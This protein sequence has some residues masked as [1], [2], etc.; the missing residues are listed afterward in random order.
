MAIRNLMEDVVASVAGEV[1]A[2]QKGELPHSELYWDDIIAYVLNRV[3]ARYITSERG[4]LH[5]RIDSLAHVQQRSDILF[6]VHEAISH[7]RT[8]RD[9]SPK[10]DYAKMSGKSL[11]F[12]HVLGE[13]A[14]QTT[15]TPIPDMEITLLYRGA[16]AVMIDEGWKNPFTTRRATRGFFH[17]WPN[18][19]ESSMPKEGTVDFTLVFSHHKFKKMEIPLKLPVVD[20]FTMNRSHIVPM[21]LLQ[22]AEGVDISF[23][24]E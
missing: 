22:T 23:L 15:F 11:F 4:I 21:T 12:P 13:V 7:I 18:L 24:Y 14:E 2:G 3:P 19:D 9:S 10:T 1:L 6:L 16:K 5:D 8:R 17:F 20:T